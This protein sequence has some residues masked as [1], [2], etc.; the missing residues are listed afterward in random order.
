MNTL[1]IK[2]ECAPL[3]VMALWEGLAVGLRGLSHLFLF[4]FPTMDPVPDVKLVL[5][6]FWDLVSSVSPDISVPLV[7]SAMLKV[8]YVEVM[9]VEIIMNNIICTNPVDR[10]N[11]RM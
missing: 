2:S 5:V 7:D 10:R 9:Y 6:V 3:K 1:P 4:F 11:L 8:L